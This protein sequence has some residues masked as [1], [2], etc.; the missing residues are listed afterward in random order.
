MTGNCYS[1]NSVLSDIIRELDPNAPPA[2]PLDLLSTVSSI[3]HQ[4]SER[5]RREALART[6]A[7]IEAGFVATREARIK[8]KLE[9]L[10]EE[11]EEEEETSEDEWDEDEYED[12]IPSREDVEAF[13]NG[14]IDKEAT[15]PVL[16]RAIGETR[17]DHRKRIETL[18]DRIQ[19]YQLSKFVL[20]DLRGDPPRYVEGFPVNLINAF[21][22]LRPHVLFMNTEMFDCLQCQVKGRR[23]SRNMNYSPACERCRRHGDPCL[24]KDFTHP[25]AVCWWFARGQETGDIEQ[26]ELE[27]LERLVN[28][29]QAEG[30]QALPVWPEVGGNSS[31]NS[32]EEEMPKKWQDFL[33]GSAK[34]KISTW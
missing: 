14:M 28:K 4:R 1:P 2:A 31:N 15:G 32:D 16:R 30:I 24:V 7:E 13:I 23:C 27:W 8:E 34:R 20:E 10:E 33:K 26:V 3:F 22:H 25:V 12:E 11:E 19:G 6:D 21:C 17:E 5:L 18:E 9:E 29:G